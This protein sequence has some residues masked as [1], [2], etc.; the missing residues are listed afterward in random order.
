MNA[1][2]AFNCHNGRAFVK[3]DRLDMH[4]VIEIV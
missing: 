3:I 2:G 1:S 4:G